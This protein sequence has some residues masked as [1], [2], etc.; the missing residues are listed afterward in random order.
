MNAIGADW[1]LPAQPGTGQYTLFLQRYGQQPDGDLLSGIL[2]DGGTILGTSRD[3]PHRMQM[4][5]KTVDMTSAILDTYQR[6]HLD[7]LV[8]LGGGGTQG[9]PGQYLG[10]RWI[11]CPAPSCDPWGYSAYTGWDDLIFEG[12]AITDRVA[13]AAHWQ[14]IQEDYM[15]CLLYTHDAADE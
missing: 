12:M 2:T 5:N 15:I 6:H 14:M 9:G 3:K 13:A 8:C 4:G 10:G 7:A 1:N 11:T